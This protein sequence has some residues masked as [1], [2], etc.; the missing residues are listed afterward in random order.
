MLVIVVF[1]LRILAVMV[2]AG[3][4]AGREAGGGDEEL[5]AE[6]AVLGELEDGG[7]EVEA[8]DDEDVGG[9]ELFHVRGAGLEGVGIVAGADEAVGADLVAT[10]LMHEVVED[11]VGG[12]DLRDGGGETEG[13]GKG[14][15]EGECAH[16]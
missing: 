11:G 4:G 1:I 6:A 16:G 13:G 12:D 8:V 14:E 7:L 9:D 2:V 15:E 5:A 10:D 3:A